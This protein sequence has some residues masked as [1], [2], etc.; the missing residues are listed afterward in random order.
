[1]KKE[2]VIINDIRELVSLITDIPDDTV[3]EIDFGEEETDIETVDSGQ[4][5]DDS[6]YTLSGVKLNGKPATKGVYLFNGKKIVIK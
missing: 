4:L 2:T 5:T 3:L 6:W 1:M